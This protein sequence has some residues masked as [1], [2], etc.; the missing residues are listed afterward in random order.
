MTRKKEKEIIHQPDI[1][2]K[3][4]ETVTAYIRSNT[5][6]CIY[7]LIAF[8]IIVAGAASYFVYAHYQDQ[9]MQYELT[10]GIKAFELY[11]RSAAA[12][13]IDKAD[14]IFQKIASASRG[15]SRYIAKMYL[16]KINMA[17][18]KTQ[19]AAKLYQEVSLNSSNQS[20]AYLANNALKNIEKK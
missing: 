2:V 7:G 1:L 14:G 9:K 16:A 6:Q 5:K 13:D 17:R 18:G 8:F 3:T 4:L 19:E 10:Q 15:K 20:L 12:S 11:G